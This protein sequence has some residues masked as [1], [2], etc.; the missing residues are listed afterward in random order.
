MKVTIIKSAAAGVCLG[1]VSGLPGTLA[2]PLLLSNVGMVG[3]TIFPKISLIWHTLLAG[4]AVSLALS[5]LFSET[6]NGK[7][8]LT[9]LM[10]PPFTML[11]LPVLSV[12]LSSCL[13]IYWEAIAYAAAMFLTHGLLLLGLFHFVINSS[14]MKQKNNTHDA[15]GYGHQ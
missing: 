6:K 15:D 5:E 9:L 11:A 4:P 10:F 14:T 1:A 13:I 3:G 7:L 12:A 8:L 2:L